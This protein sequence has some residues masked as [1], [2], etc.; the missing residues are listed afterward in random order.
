MRLGRVKFE[1]SYVVDLDDNEMVRLAKNSLYDDLDNI[2]KY[3]EYPS[4]EYIEDCSLSKDDI[5][6]FLTESNDYYDEDE[7]ND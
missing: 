3:G 4:T 6:E 1:I 5:P 2:V 7:E